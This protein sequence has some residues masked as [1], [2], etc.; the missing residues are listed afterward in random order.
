MRRRTINALFAVLLLCLEAGD[1]VRLRD[2]DA[3]GRAKASSTIMD[4]LAVS[5]RDYKAI[6]RAHFWFQSDGGSGAE[7]AQKYTVLLHP[8]SV[9]GARQALKKT[10]GTVTGFTLCPGTYIAGWDGPRPLY[11]RSSK[12]LTG[13]LTVVQPQATD[14]L[15]HSKW[16]ALQVAQ[17]RAES[18]EW[19]RGPTHSSMPDRDVQLGMLAALLHD[20]SKG[21][22][23]VFSCYSQCQKGEDGLVVLHELNPGDPHSPK[24]CFKDSTADFT[25]FGG[26]ESDEMHARFSADFMQKAMHGG[27]TPWRGTLWTKCPEPDEIW[28]K[29]GNLVGDVSSEPKLVARIES[30]EKEIVGDSDIR[31]RFPGKAAILAEDDNSRLKFL[32]H[33]ALFKELT[34]WK[35]ANHGDS[36]ASFTAKQ[37]MDE[38]KATFDL[39][40][41]EWAKMSFATGFSWTLGRL[42]MPGREKLLTTR[43]YVDLVREEVKGPGY[44]TMVGDAKLCNKTK[45]T[46]AVQLALLVAASDIASGAPPRLGRREEAPVYVEPSQNAAASLCKGASKPESPS[47]LQTAPEAV[48]EEPLLI[49]GLAQLQ[50]SAL[51]KVAAP[52]SILQTTPQTVPPKTLVQRDAASAANS[53]V[54]EQRGVENKPEGT[55]GHLDPSATLLSTERQSVTPG[56]DKGDKV[57]GAGSTTTTTSSPATS[58]GEQIEPIGSPP[59][60]SLTSYVSQ[61]CKAACDGESTE[62]HIEQKYPSFDVYEKLNFEYEKSDDVSA[63]APKKKWSLEVLNYLDEELVQILRSAEAAHCTPTLADGG[64]LGGAADKGAVG[65]AAE[66]PA[67]GSGPSADKAGKSALLGG[68]E[69]AAATAGSPG[70]A[71]GAA[72]GAAGGNPAGQNAA[73]AAGPSTGSPQLQQQQQ[74]QL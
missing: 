47:F 2:E 8:D 72:A 16:A 37:L 48:D 9:E 26:A 25:R 65:P 21:G 34:A 42:D 32:T 41:E 73:A 52:D 63:A 11:A 20:V 39:T 31:D 60:A 71:S 44:P 23:C 22:D 38:W 61:I 14:L 69:A 28:T 36:Q 54:V 45:A 10:G 13:N 27:E 57:G 40:A 6:P 55:T 67:A 51:P 29:V 49:R 46:S 64:S 1:A 15:E 56:D 53:A 33:M 3:D 66:K 74:P 58:C 59:P 70:A 43:N 30:F 18:S 4:K 35:V 17:W 68:A 12:E 7:K 19:T 24:V 5:L 62:C 50:E